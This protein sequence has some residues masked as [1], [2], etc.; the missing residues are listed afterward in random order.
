MSAIEAKTYRWERRVSG[1]EWAAFAGT[2]PVR[3]VT[4]ASFARR[5]E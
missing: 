4:Y 1:A 2:I 5:D 3:V